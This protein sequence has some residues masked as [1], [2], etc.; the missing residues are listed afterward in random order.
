MS[1]KKERTSSSESVASS[2]GSCRTIVSLSSSD[3]LCEYDNNLKNME[4]ISKKK[5]N[6]FINDKKKDVITRRRQRENKNIA[7]SP[8]IVDVLHLLIQ[9][10]QYLNLHDNNKK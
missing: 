8:Q 6:N 4:E 7:N 2:F 10:N 5:I 1:E 9:K 3:S